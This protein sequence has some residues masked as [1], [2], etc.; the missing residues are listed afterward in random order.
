MVH[1]CVANGK[2]KFLSFLIENNG[3]YNWQVDSIVSMVNNGMIHLAAY[4]S[5]FK[6]L[7]YLLKQMVNVNNDNNSNYDINS[8]DKVPQ[9][10][11]NN[12]YFE[13]SPQRDKLIECNVLTL[14]AAA[15]VARNNN[16][17]NNPNPNNLRC[18]ELLLNYPSIDCNIIVIDSI[19]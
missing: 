6:I 13:S 14:S 18:F 15:F 2:A 5:H 3:K 1:Q 12:R 4:L 19:I 11:R 16:N 17:N 9:C 8:V 10:V 7:D